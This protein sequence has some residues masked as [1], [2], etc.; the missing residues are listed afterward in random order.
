MRN[1]SL[2]AA[3]ASH[4]FSPIK[5]R[6]EIDHFWSSIRN[7]QLQLDRSSIYICTTNESIRSFN[8]TFVQPKVSLYKRAL[9]NIMPLL[10]CISLSLSVWRRRQICDVKKRLPRSLWERECSRPL[11][12]WV[13]TTTNDLL[14][15]GR[16]DARP[17]PLEIEEWH[18]S[19]G[20][21]MH[22]KV[23]YFK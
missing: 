19:E 11:T 10:R 3:F 5:N 1:E 2:K 4:D 6:D 8:S 20:L 17:R 7:S 16:K 21:R 22:C 14:S 15:S 23:A 9:N 13:V 18:K 12:S